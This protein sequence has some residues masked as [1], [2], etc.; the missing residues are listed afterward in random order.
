MQQKMVEMEERVQQKM[1]EKFDAQK[2][3]TR[4]DITMSIIAQLQLLNPEIR[5]TT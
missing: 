3:T 2:D 1:Q 5:N 4:Q